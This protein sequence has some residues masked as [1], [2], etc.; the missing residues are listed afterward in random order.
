MSNGVAGW[1]AGAVANRI[2]KRWRGAPTLLVAL[3]CATPTL[4]SA[5]V[6][7]D[8]GRSPFS[9]ITTSQSI[10]LLAGHFFGNT[11]AAGVGAQA[12]TSLGFRFRTSLSGPI[13][14][15]F[16]LSSIQ[17]QRATID[18][19]KP[20]STRVGGPIDLHLIT[21]E[22]GLGLNITG[23]KT[24]HGLA[25]YLNVGLGFVAPSHTVSD[26]GG[27][28]AGSGFTFAPAVGMHVKLTRAFHLELEARD[29]TIRYEW[30]LAYFVPLDANGNLLTPILDQ[31]KHRSKQMTHN[32]TL[33]LGLAYRFNF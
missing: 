31:T 27:F 9:D 28:R 12:A 29:N 17:S 18:A 24:W 21:A 30:P 33:S 25:P 15:V 26:P 23:Q 5:Q 14:L 7:H 22:L 10:S 19:T 2:P 32:F 13:D 11:A 8:P 20:E 4:L 1:S 3:A 6:G 16:S